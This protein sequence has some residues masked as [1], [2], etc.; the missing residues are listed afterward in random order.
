MSNIIPFPPL[1]YSIQDAVRV[2]TLSRPRIYQ[3]ISQGK[4]RA[5]KIG[6]RTVIL[7]ESLQKL[8]DEGC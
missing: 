6:R 4:L 5:S 2:T 7:A 8:I 3:L 1:A